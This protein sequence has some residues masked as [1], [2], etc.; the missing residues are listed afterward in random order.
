MRRNKNLRPPKSQEKTKEEKE[1]EVKQALDLVARGANEQEK[2]QL[3]AR[4]GSKPYILEEGEWPG[5]VFFDDKPVGDNTVLIINRQHIFYDMVYRP[6]LEILASESKNPE[7]KK[8]RDAID[9][10]LVTFV[11]TCK[12]HR[13]D[14]DYQMSWEE[15]EDKIKGDWGEHLKSFLREIK[16]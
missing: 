10:L 12:N 16:K 15:F 1:K 3:V 11:N 4:F 6:L 13:S 2:A 5:P 7:L 8:I 9:L 14:S